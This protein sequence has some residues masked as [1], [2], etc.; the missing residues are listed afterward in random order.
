[1]S[2]RPPAA[3]KPNSYLSRNKMLLKTML[4]KNVL[5]FFATHFTNY[6]SVVMLVCIR[7]CN[8]RGVCIC[9]WGQCKAIF[10]NLG[11]HSAS[12]FPA[13]CVLFYVRTYYIFIFAHAGGDSVFAPLS[14][15]MLDTLSQLNGATYLRKRFI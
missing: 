15:L 7:M 11:I 3:D 12:V 1:M 9:R 8:K 14:I 13:A 4:C 2:S 5:L 6:C 10:D